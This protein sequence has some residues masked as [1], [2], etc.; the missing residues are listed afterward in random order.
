[1]RLF[2]IQ[3]RFVYDALQTGSRFLSEPLKAGEDWEM[4]DSPASVLAYDWLCGE[5]E[6]RGLVRPTGERIYP[7]WAWR[8]YRGSAR[9][10]PDLRDSMMKAWGREERHVLLTLE[11]PDHQ[12]LLH[13]YDAWHYPLNHWYLGSPKAT[14][15]FERRCKRAGAPL[16][17]DVPLGDLALR[18][19]LEASWQAIFDLATVQR[20]MQGSLSSQA[21]QATF[22]ELRR[23]QVRSAVEFGLGRPAKLLPLPRA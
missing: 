5:M 13:D 14:N 1:M 18:A 19:E 22:W 9:P 2:S 11:V 10:K 20:T 4:A 7:I 16:Y 6:A 17:S 3:P 12:V 23:D 8:Q 21:I 15:D